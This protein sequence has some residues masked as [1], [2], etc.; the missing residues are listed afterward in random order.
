MR[1]LG[2]DLSTSTGF[3]TVEVDSLEDQHPRLVSRGVIQLEKN[4]LEYGPYPD[5]YWLAAEDVAKRVFDVVNKENPDIIVIEETNLGKNRYAQKTLEFIHCH[6][7]KALRRDVKP[8]FV[9]VYLSSS[10]WRQALGLQ[11]TKEQKKANAKLAKAKREA[12]AMGMKLDKKKLGIKGKV[13][14]KH[15]AIAYVNERF[16]LK[17]KVQD[18]DIAD[19]ICLAVAMTKNPTPCDGT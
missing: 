5:C 7:V 19:A 1:I 4:I 15:V 18:D 10:A 13:N 17:L 9:V 3:A 14:K 6:V 11:L 12:A 2:L 16:A 8:P